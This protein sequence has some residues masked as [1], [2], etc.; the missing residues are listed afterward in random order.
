[1]NKENWDLLVIGAGS[2]G[3]AAANRAAQYGQR[4][5]LIEANVLG[6][7]CVNVGCVP[8]KIMWYATDIAE[9]L[10]LAADY[11][12]AFNKNATH[13]F[14]WPILI[15]KR[16]AYIEHLHA[17]YQRG[18]DKNSVTVIKGEAQFVDAHTVSVNGHLYHAS[19]II[20]ATGGY[21]TMPSIIGAEH[22]INSDGF[23]EL[24]E[25]PVRV[26]IVGAGYI[27]V[28]LASM[29]SALG[30][31]VTLVLR[32]DKPLREFDAGISE[33]LLQ[34]LKKAGVT[35]RAHSNILQLEKTT[36][37]LIAHFDDAS[38]EQTDCVIWAIGRQ[39]NI[40]KLNLNAAKIKLDNKNYVI[41]D[42]YQNTNVTGIYALGDVTGRAAL[43]PV[44][45]AAGRRLA[46]RLFNAQA[47]R[48]LLYDVI[49]SVV[50]TH[51]P[52]AVV[53]LTEA[54]AREQYG[55][56]IKIYQTEFTSM[57]YAFSDNANKTWMKLIVQGAEEKV[58]GCHMIGNGV[59]EILQGFAVAIRMGATKKD[60]DDT[61]AIHPTSGEELVT[62]R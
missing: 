43:T 61:L 56:D 20:I 8:K 24:S 6:G 52:I 48:R 19:H 1:M 27:G 33:R 46:D 57:R 17:A 15:A 54:Q 28:E 22:G 31:A 32:Q 7:T 23:F 10:D 60:F 25:Q 4:V 51:P 49:P 30:S 2:G 29:L 36:E 37:Q 18:L 40:K 21:P 58:I 47:Q 38:T 44:A 5:V 12:F 42:E 39:A 13:G 62:L 50:F 59:D 11:G 16:S 9:T 3:I 45:V 41:T 53:G 35:I 55:D 14:S 26:M 34:V